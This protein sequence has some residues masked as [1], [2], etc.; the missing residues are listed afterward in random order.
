M[1]LCIGINCICPWKV[2][3][4]VPDPQSGKLPTICH[5]QPSGWFASNPPSSLL[6]EWSHWRRSERRLGIWRALYLGKSRQSGARA[7]GHHQEESLITQD[8][9]IP[10]ARSTSLAVP[11]LFLASTAAQRTSRVCHDSVKGRLVFL[12]SSWHRVSDWYK[13]E[14]AIT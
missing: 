6:F 2:G 4:S 7:I 8:L 10:A 5:L 11:R 13:S 14:Y 12:A 3:I 9:S 1:S